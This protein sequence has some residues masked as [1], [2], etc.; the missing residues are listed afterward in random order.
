MV[1]PV[2]KDVTAGAETTRL[3]AL[4]DVP[5]GTRVRTSRGGPVYR[6]AESPEPGRMTRLRA[7]ESG[8]LDAYTTRTDWVEVVPE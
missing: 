4:E 8:G 7:E 5:V 3:F 6:V 1:Y 2:P